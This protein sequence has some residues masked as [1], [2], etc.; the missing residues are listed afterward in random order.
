MKDEDSGI[1]II[2]GGPVGLVAAMYLAPRFG[3]VTVLEKR[4]DPRSRLGAVGRSITVMLS[5]RG[6]RALSEV[7]LEDFVRSICVPIHGRCAHLADGSSHVTPYSRDRRPIWS[8]ERA[9]LHRLLLDAAEATPGVRLCFDQ[10]VREVDLDSPAVVV[11]SRTLRCRLVL[12]CDGAHSTTRAALVSRGARE[13]V[14]TLEMAYQEIDVPGGWLDPS[15]MHYWPTGDGFF[16]AFPLPSG[17]FAGSLFMRLDGPAPSYASVSGGYDLLGMFTSRFPEPA[18]AIG[19]LAGQLASKT[20]ST[21]TI[22][23]CDRW[24]WEGKLALL[25]DACHAMAPFMGHGM[26]C[27]FEDVRTFVGCLDSIDDTASAL[28]VYEKSRVEEA[29][30]ISAL[31]QQ[32]YHTMANPPPDKAAVLVEEALRERLFDLFPERF[33]PLYEQCAFT[34][35]SYATLLRN[36]LLLESLV[37]ELLGIHGPELVSAPASTLRARVSGAAAAITKES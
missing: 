2:G 10:Q 16:G 32:H 13:E 1:V 30:A 20:V 33:V 17:D 22:A 3:S 6:W 31:S 4:P 18:A 19:D 28:A 5:T 21:I 8:V 27:G 26:N 37:E 9:R 29:K 36:D 14:R 15:T 25:G 11:G 35:E 23:S 12:G 24:V 34:E 7:G